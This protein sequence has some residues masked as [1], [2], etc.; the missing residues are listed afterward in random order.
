MARK[1]DQLSRS[2]KHFYPLNFEDLLAVIPQGLTEREVKLFALLC[3]DLSVI[4]IRQ[5]MGLREG[6]YYDRL[7]RFLKKTG[8]RDR[9]GLMSARIYQLWSYVKEAQVNARASA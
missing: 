5:A 4:Q 7:K 3:S 9:T 1:I 2:L 6:T 8:F